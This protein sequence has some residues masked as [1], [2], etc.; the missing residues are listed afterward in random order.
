MA[1]RITMQFHLNSRRRA[2][3][4]ARLVRSL[5]LR[6]IVRAFIGGALAA[7]CLQIHAQGIYLLGEIHD[8]PH[9]HA[10]RLALIEAL[11]AKAPNSVIAMEQFDRDQQTLLDGAMR[12]CAD[13]DCVIRAAG[14]PGWQ[15]R[16][17][18]PVIELALNKQI[19]IIGANVSGKDTFKIARGGFESALDSATISQFGLDRELDSAFNLKQREAIDAGHCR[20][21]PKQALAGMVNAQVARDVWMAKTIR[22]NA[23]QPL[24]LLA[25][26]G[27]IRKDIGIYYWL[28]EAERARSEVHAYLEDSGEEPNPPFD[29]IHRVATVERDDPCA[30]FKRK[31]ALS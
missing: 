13:A 15:W 5:R 30:V 4:F 17:Y 3:L 23:T 10:Q 19:R 22:E 2:L 18:K 11:L 31:P 29:Q 25:G 1:R 16:F 24:I 6:S 9:G 7:A 12:S 27:H 14:G 8:N 21:L 26:N 20:M 28:G